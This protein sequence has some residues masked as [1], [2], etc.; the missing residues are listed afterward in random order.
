MA[1]MQLFFIS[2]AFVEE[3]EDNSL[4]IGLLSVMWRCA[5]RSVTDLKVIRERHTPISLR[6]EHNKMRK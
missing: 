5:D 6:S 3:S 1:T 4:K 2:D